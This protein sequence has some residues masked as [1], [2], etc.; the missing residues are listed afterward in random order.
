[1]LVEELMTRNIISIDSGKT[2]FDACKQLSK[3]KVGSLVIIDKNITIGLITEL[4][5]IEKV[6]L[7]NRDPKETN[8]IEI[9]TP[10]IKTIHAL[11]PVKKAARVMKDNNIKKLPVIL[12]NEIIGIITESD[13]TSTIEA[14]SESIE[15]MAKFYTE[16]RNNLEKMMDKWENILINLK[17]YKKFTGKDEFEKIVR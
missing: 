6:I 16:S 13:L 4:D 10:N 12:N 11:A 5:I 9:M 3:N 2:V 14:F 8:I 15:E 7:Q 17:E 1:M